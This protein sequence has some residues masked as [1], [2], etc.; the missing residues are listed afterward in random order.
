MTA[1]EI[2][3]PLGVVLHSA[4]AVMDSLSEIKSHCG[5]FGDRISKEDREHLQEILDNSH[6]A[7]ATIV[8]STSSQLSMINN[9][10]ILSKLSNHALTITP[11]LEQASTLVDNVLET[12]RRNAKEEGVELRVFEEKSIYQLDVDWLLVDSERVAQIIHNIVANAVES[13]KQGE[14][15]QEVELRV[16]ASLTAPSQADLTVNFFPA[17]NRGLSTDNLDANWVPGQSVYLHFVIRDTGYGLTKKDMSMLLERLSQETPQLSASG[18]SRLGLYIAK[19]LT[20]MQGG[21]IGIASNEG[22]GATLAFYVKTRLAMPPTRMARIRSTPTDDGGQTSYSILMVE[23][24]IV[25]QTVLSKQL[26]RLGHQVH[27]ASNGTEALEV[28]RRSSQCTTVPRSMSVPTLS[29]THPAGPHASENHFGISVILMDVEMPIM[30]GIECTRKIRE[31]EEEGE[32]E[33]RIPIIA[34]T[35]NK[36]TDHAGTGHE[37]VMDDAIVKP[38]K[39]VDLMKKIERVV[40]Y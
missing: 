30:D 4:E 18:T 28:L 22:S 8:S 31:M 3:N 36:G 9:L 38:F 26:K 6:D 13:A 29:V 10:S 34:V 2:R 5:Q 14:E 24:N 35:A 7:L 19:E 23:D 25:N 21:R 27:L 33:G 40:G 16:G 20:E 1:H 17:R 11:S 12:F 37:G 32:L 39:V 15:R